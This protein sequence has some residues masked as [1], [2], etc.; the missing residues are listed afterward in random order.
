ME[1]IRKLAPDLVLIDTGYTHTPEAVGVYLLLGDRPALIETGPATT[2]DAVLEGVR[3]AGVDPRQ[4]QAA[5]V[6][7]I[8]LDH[9]GGVGTLAQRLPQ[10]QVYAHP[11]GAPHLVDP[12]RLIVSAR[13]LYGDDLDRLLGEPAPIPGERVHLVADGDTLLLGSR[14]LRA[15]DTPG[16]ARHHH[17]FFDEQSGDLFTGDVAGVALP[18]SRYVRPPTPPPDFDVPSWK[19]SL[20][21]M[22]A[23]NP[24]RLL[25][26]HFGAH[27]W[28]GELLDQL[29]VRIDRMVDRVRGA[30]AAGEDAA[31][32]TEQVRQEALQ[33]IDAADGPGSSARY[34]V[35]MP[36]YQSVLGLI[37]Y[38]EKSGA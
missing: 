25:L 8:H 26:T 14:R 34:E 23:L 1:R 30:L 19:A 31:A 37:R 5:A 15:V 28:V 33:E 21:R 38:I 24:S 4:L 29:A 3:A 20:T 10:L 35:I 18:D 6:T 32:I 36:V 17:A 13:R 11:I 16:H 27:A 12:A 22:R 7:H 9:A 2:V